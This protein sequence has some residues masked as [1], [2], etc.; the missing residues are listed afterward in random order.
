MREEAIHFYRIRQPTDECIGLNLPAMSPHMIENESYYMTHASYDLCSSM[1]G[2]N[3]D[4][5][6]VTV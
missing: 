6:V 2:E 4:M 5:S 1:K 3:F